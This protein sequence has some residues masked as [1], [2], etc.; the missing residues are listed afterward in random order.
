MAKSC[1]ATVGQQQRPICEIKRFADAAS[2]ALGEQVDA[3]WQINCRNPGPENHMTGDSEKKAINAVEL[4]QD[5]SACRDH[6]IPCV[7]QMASLVRTSP[8]CCND[9]LTQ[10]EYA[11]PRRS[12]WFL[13][14]DAAQNFRVGDDVYD[15]HIV[16]LFLRQTLEIAVDEAD[17]MQTLDMAVSDRRSVREP[18]AK[19]DMTAD[20]DVEERSSR[21]SRSVTGSA[22]SLRIQELEEQL[23]AALHVPRQSWHDLYSGASECESM[24]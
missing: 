22:E 14:T 13:T 12:W 6:E 8:L 24:P 15:A 4:N 2:N 10:L 9:T 5:F 19:S 16:P 21:A 23:A 17:W 1:C 11:F 7:R 20:M 3:W 18:R